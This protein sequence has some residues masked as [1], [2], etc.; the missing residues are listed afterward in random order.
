V[1]YEWSTEYFIRAVALIKIILGVIERLD[2]ITM[3][4]S[5]LNA[6]TMVLLILLIA[7]SDNNKKW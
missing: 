2:Q 5:P 7:K 4:Q 3:F 1:V 6:I